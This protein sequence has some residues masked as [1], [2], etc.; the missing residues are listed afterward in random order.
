MKQRTTFILP[1]EKPL[2]NADEPP[3]QICN[4]NDS[5]EA[6]GTSAIRRSFPSNLMLLVLY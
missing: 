2:Q 1:V 3:A 6:A 4:L 5:I